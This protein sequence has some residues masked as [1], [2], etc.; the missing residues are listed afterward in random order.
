MP[1]SPSRGTASES[2][3]RSWSACHGGC[4]SGNKPHRLKPLVELLPFDGDILDEESALR[5]AGAFPEDYSPEHAAH[6]APALWWPQTAAQRSAPSALL[7]PA[8]SAHHADSGQ[9][10][11]GRPWGSHMVSLA[12]PSPSL[13]QRTFAQKERGIV[14]SIPTS[15]PKANAVNKSSRSLSLFGMQ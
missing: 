6:A 4:S 8:P 14:A 11:S 2:L 3:P 13:L 12:N 15:S 7:V 1:S 5:E 10:L 9:V